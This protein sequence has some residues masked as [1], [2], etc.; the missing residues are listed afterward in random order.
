MAK[1]GSSPIAGNEGG[2]AGRVTAGK[3][4]EVLYNFV[5]VDHKFEEKSWAVRRTVNFFTY[6]V[7]Y[8]EAEEGGDAS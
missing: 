3:H 1:P 5:G 6:I 8:C 7:T 4:T 2:D